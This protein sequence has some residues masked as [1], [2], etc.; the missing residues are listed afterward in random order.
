ML[1]VKLSGREKILH[2]RE[3]RAQWRQ[4][5]KHDAHIKS[6]LD[7]S[8]GIPEDNTAK[9]LNDKSTD[10]RVTKIISK[11]IS[12]TGWLT[13]LAGFVIVGYGL[14]HSKGYE[15]IDVVLVIVLPGIGMIVTGLFL[16]VAGQ[17]ARAMVD[18]ATHN[19]HILMHLRGELESA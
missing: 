2:K 16:I 19:K 7:P 11:I 10:Y 18:N 9:D 3:K 1:I 13:L 17:I 15:N 4:P 8:Q 12:F 6:S 5:V 14:V